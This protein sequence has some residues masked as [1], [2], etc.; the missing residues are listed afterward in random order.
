MK[1]SDILK[2]FKNIQPDADFSRHSRAEI[3][4]SPQ[5]ERRTMR[6]VF[7]FLHVVETGAAVAL[8]GFFILILTGSF[9]PTRSIAPVQYAVI[10]PAGLHAE[11]QA[12]DMQI[13]LADIEYPQV[14]T[15][16]AA[17]PATSAALA[18]AF[19]TVLRTSK[20]S[21]SAALAT[22]PAAASTSASAASTTSLSVDQAL[23]QLTQ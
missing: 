19:A 20:A 11:A 1:L 12:I 10:D 3:L 17:T 5:N 16:A 4:I 2:Q 23:Q 7:A 18:K 6:D 22:S 9:S 13:Q 8:V 15:T 14:T 21:S